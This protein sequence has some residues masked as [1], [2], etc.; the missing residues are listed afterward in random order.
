MYLFSDPSLTNNVMCA[1]EVRISQ[2]INA[3]ECP[4]D[5]VDSLLKNYFSKP[6][7][8]RSQ[9]VFS[10]DIQEYCS[11]YYYSAINP[12]N[13]IIYFKVRGIR[14]KNSKE[15]FHGF[16]VM[17]EKTILLLERAIQ[18][19]LPKLVADFHFEHFNG[20][21]MKLSDTYSECLPCFEDSLCQ[22]KTSIFPF[23]QKGET[24]CNDV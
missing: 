1:S 5:F 3:H 6:R 14:S 22:L 8:L 7:Y 17:Q 9:D 23:L 16:Y 15:N 20:T 19:Y 12:N 2:I 13:T 10:V 21:D 18:S 11:D 24:D 4:S